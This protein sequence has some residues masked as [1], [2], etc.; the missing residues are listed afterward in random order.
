MNVA[1]TNSHWY[2]VKQQL[3]SKLQPHR[4]TTTIF[5]TLCCAQLHWP[6]LRSPFGD[7][8]HNYLQYKSNAINMQ[9]T[10]LIF[11]FVF[12]FSFIFSERTEAFVQHWLNNTLGTER[13]WYY[14]EYAVIR[15]AIQRYVLH[16]HDHC[17]LSVFS[18]NR[19]KYGPKK[20]LNTDTF[21]A[22]MVLVSEKMI[23]SNEIRTHNQLVRRQTLTYLVEFSD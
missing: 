8:S 4:P 9:S 14:H 21:Y 19:G 5:F 7:A 12:C 17:Y 10:I 23:D 2:K 22:A 1:D 15:S 16:D 6:E 3:K 18:P 13:Y 20:T 11:C